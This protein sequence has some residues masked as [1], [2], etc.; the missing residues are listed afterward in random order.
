MSERND[1]PKELIQKNIDD[2]NKGLKDFKEEYFLNE[3]YQKNMKS[4]KE[5]LNYGEF[6]SAKEVIDNSNFE[7]FDIKIIESYY[8][9]SIYMYSNDLERV[10]ADINKKHELEQKAYYLE[11]FIEDSVKKS[12]PKE[13]KTIV[14]PEKIKKK[15]IANIKIPTA[16]KEPLVIPKERVEL[17]KPLVDYDKLKE[18]Y[19]HKE[20]KFINK[21]IVTLDKS[22][23][24]QKAHDHKDMMFKASKTL[25][26][27]LKRNVN[28]IED[29]KR[30]LEELPKNYK[31]EKKHLEENLNDFFTKANKTNDAVKQYMEKIDKSNLDNKSK[32]EYKLGLYDELAKYRYSERITKAMPEVKTDMVNRSVEHFKLIN[33]QLDTPRLN[34]E[35]KIELLDKS[36]QLLKDFNKLNPSF[37]QERAITKIHNSQV[38]NL[39]H[40]GMER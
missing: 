26:S 28:Q 3:E 31:V 39:K 5:H 22:I 29:I 34:K 30:V 1:I 27:E 9:E 19:D 21:L 12:L 32:L 6:Y 11:D 40:R 25:S 36:S 2:F 8:E 18:Q 35:T 4:V 10:Q 37:K 7:E 17:N 33:K 23:N 15:N 13:H 20:N 16:N 24:E 14:K 38:R